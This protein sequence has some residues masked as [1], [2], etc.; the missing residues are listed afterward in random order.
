MHHPVAGISRD[1][2]DGAGSRSRQLRRRISAQLFG[3]LRESKEIVVIGPDPLL[4]HYSRAEG[5]DPESLATCQILI[6]GSPLTVVGVP[7]RIWYGAVMRDV[8]RVKR[9]MLASGRSCIL[10]PQRALEGIARLHSRPIANRDPQ[11]LLQAIR[12]APLLRDIDACRYGRGHD[13]VGCLAVELA[14]GTPCLG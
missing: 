8:H 2:T 9:N 7:N 11:I 13:P 5:L 12:T 14:T 6:D 4:I 3:I 10:V 1:D